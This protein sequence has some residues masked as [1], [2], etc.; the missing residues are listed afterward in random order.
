MVPNSPSPFT[1]YT[2]QI[3]EMIVVDPPDS[4]VQD[5]D[6]L[7]LMPS[8][9]TQVV[10]VSE[11]RQPRHRPTISQRQGGDRHGRTSSSATRRADRIELARN[12]AYWAA[13]RPGKRCAP[14]PSAG[15]VAGS[16]RY[17]RG[18]CTVIEKRADVRVANSARDKRVAIFRTVA[19]RLIYL[20][21]D[22]DRDN[23]PFV[24]DK[25]GKPLAKN[26]LK[27]ARVRKGDLEGDQPVGR[28]SRR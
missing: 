11:K 3:K 21:M 19:D 18:T 26:P 23:S 5:R 6:A 20:H 4:A 25:A 16:R 28:W 1:A 22:S 13:R 15:R 2:K 9:M 24:T 17:C 7:P 12:D 27:D 14:A 10:I 8:D